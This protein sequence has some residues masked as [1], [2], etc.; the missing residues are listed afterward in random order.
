V[1]SALPPSPLTALHP[2]NRAALE[3]TAALLRRLGHEVNEREVDYGPLAPPAEF[4]VRYLEG[5]S[6][7]AAALAHPERLER[8]IRA[9]ARLGGLL[10]PAAFEWARSREVPYA[11]RLNEALADHDVLM[12]PVTPAPAPRI[13]AC[14]GRGWL[15][16]TVVAAAAVPYAACWNLTGQ[17]ACSVPA[18]FAPDGLPR[19]VQLVSRPNED[20][21]LVALAAELEAARSASDG[22]AGGSGEGP[23]AGRP[24]DFT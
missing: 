9:L 24:P 4:T 15:W 13:G 7:D 14:E 1:A 20:A 22:G 10:P 18:G 17:P 12:T 23:V 21:T 19:A 2:D 11:E 16:T 6:D 8:R 5:L 3:E